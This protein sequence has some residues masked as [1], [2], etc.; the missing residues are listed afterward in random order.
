M[1]SI[2]TITKT[3][4]PSRLYP[5]TRYINLFVH[6]F[7]FSS[8]VLL[9]SIGPAVG[10]DF[11]WEFWGTKNQATLFN[12]HIDTWKDFLKA[13][14]RYYIAN[15]RL[16][17]VNPNYSSVHKEVELAF[18]NNMI[19]KEPTHQVATQKFSD[20][21]VSLDHADKLPNGAILYLICVLVSL[22]LLIQNERSKRWEIVVT[23]EP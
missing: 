1:S 23:N 9:R 22:N 12:K 19:L 5:H 3:P 7:G 17:R 20:G 10:R 8:L 2:T 21:F 16:D 4:Y 14:K 13:N 11:F 15:G 18:T 6:K